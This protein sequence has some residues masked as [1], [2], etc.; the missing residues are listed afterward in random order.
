MVKVRAGKS[1]AIAGA[2][3]SASEVVAPSNSLLI[4]VPNI[5]SDAR[6]HTLTNAHPQRLDSPFL[7]K[8]PSPKRHSRPASAGFRT[9]KK[10]GA[11]PAFRHIRVA[12]VISSAT[13]PDHRSGR[14]R[15]P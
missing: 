5:T 1:A 3:P 9:Q 2:N 14:R 8:K 11:R 10:A 4:A 15:R 12:R 13:R 6:T 7:P